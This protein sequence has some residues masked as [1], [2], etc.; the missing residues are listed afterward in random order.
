MKEKKHRYYV[1]NNLTMTIVSTYSFP[2]ESKDDVIK[3]ISDLY[4]KE[5]GSSKTVQSDYNSVTYIELV[6]YDNST[7]H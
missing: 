6:D 1:S 2:G 7:V 4:S 3:Y 5:V